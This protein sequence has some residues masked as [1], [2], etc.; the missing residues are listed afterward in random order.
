LLAAERALLTLGVPQHTRDAV[1]N[2]I[3]AL[4]E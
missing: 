4:R 3:N 2:Y 1:V